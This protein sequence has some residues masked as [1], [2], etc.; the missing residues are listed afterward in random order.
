MKKGLISKIIKIC[1]VVLIP[2]LAGLYIGIYS[3]GNYEDRY[4]D[5]FPR[6]FF[7]S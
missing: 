4:F 5:T 3:Y 1:I 2:V 7:L 6:S